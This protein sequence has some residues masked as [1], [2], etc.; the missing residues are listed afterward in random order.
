MWDVT[1]LQVINCQLS[2]TSFLT[3]RVC[4]KGPAGTWKVFRV[5][6]ERFVLLCDRFSRV[7]TSQ[8][9]FFPKGLLDG[10]FLN[11]HSQEVLVSLTPS[12]GPSQ[13]GGCL[14]G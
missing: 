7:F 10:G 4:S 14:T 1:D 11:I 3:S 9:A 8:E 6:K 13:S 5:F 2:T 12:S